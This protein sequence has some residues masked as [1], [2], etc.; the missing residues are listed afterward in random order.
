MLDNYKYM[1]CTYYS[2][3]V[4][5]IRS[6]SH[7]LHGIHTDHMP[8]LQEWIIVYGYGAIL[9]LMTSFPSVNL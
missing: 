5:V 6:K 9:W 2:Y 4:V 1:L 8:G 7:V 3:I